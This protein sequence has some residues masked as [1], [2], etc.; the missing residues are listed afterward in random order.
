L[1]NKD[2]SGMPEIEMVPLESIHKNPKNP[3][4][5]KDGK[6]KKLCQSIKEDPWFMRLRPIIHDEAGMILGGNM[7]YEA[8]IFLGM[9]EAPAISANDLTED[10]KKRFIIK[11]NVPGGEWDWSE[12]SNGWNNSEL[13]EWGLDVPKIDL[14]GAIDLDNDGEGDKKDQIDTCPKCGFQWVK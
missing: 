14:D 13:E 1:S 6:F 10:Q 8:C 4:I 5:I 12:L 7:R 9:K 2:K 3:R 11:D